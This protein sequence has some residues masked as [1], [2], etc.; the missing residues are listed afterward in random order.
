MLMNKSRYFF[1]LAYMIWL[2]TIGLEAAPMGTLPDAGLI[3]RESSKMPVQTKPLSGIDVE[4][5]PLK[6]PM[7]ALKNGQVIVRGFRFNGNTRFTSSTLQSLLDSYINHKL[8]FVDLQQAAALITDYYQK[9]GFL[10]VY[11]YIPEQSMTDG[12]VEMVIFE[13]GYDEKHNQ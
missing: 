6:Q 2:V 5:S 12:C 4:S 10:E 1:V 11:S 8:G 3:M 7:S 9:A 13:G